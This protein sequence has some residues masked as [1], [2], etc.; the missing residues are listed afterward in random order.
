MMR[1]ENWPT[2]L[3]L[4]VDSRRSQPFA[5][6]INDCY[7]F[8]SDWILICTGVDIAA[9]YRGQYFGAIGATR[10]LADV[11]GMENL[12][13][14]SA[15]TLQRISRRIAG[16]GDIVIRNMG[17]GL[18]FGIVIGSLDCFVNTDGLAFL[19]LDENCTCWRL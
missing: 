18:T 9:K 4:Y 7:L 16:R 12:F 13:E 6:G 8:V 10:I 19:P 5:W 17:N 1:L 14:T 3:S 11:G 2:L 15:P